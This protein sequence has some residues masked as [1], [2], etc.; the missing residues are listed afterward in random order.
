MF[1]NLKMVR[2]FLIQTIQFLLVVIVDLTMYVVQVVVVVE[3]L[4]V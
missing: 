3:E 4:T 2:D 1:L